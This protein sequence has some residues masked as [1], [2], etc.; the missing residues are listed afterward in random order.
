MCLRV[1]G[2]RLVIPTP[3]RQT[4]V[5]R[6]GQTRCDSVRF[7]PTGAHGVWRRGAPRV[8][9]VPSLGGGG[10]AAAGPRWLGSVGGSAPGRSGLGCVELWQR[11]VT[12]GLPKRCSPRAPNY[13]RSCVR[14]CLLAGRPACFLACLP[15]CL[16]ACL[17]VTLLACLP[18]CPALGGGR[19]LSGSD[20]CQQRFPQRRFP[21]R[22]NPIAL[23][24]P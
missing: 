6:F 19:S 9:G 4:E 11:R 13:P 5:D 18:A 23:K 22:R 15:S 8:V 24:A 10:G 20:T 7:V 2:G 1:I 12:R 17:L 21:Q 14:L 3:I 16:L